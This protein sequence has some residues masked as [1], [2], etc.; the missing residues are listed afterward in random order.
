VE[1][2]GGERQ[3]SRLD[4]ILASKRREIEALRTEAW[5]AATREPIDVVRALGRAKGAP[6]RL[7]AEVKRK[8]P[9]A[10]ALSR[11]LSPAARAVAYATH[12]AAMV[13]VLCDGP[14]FDGGW[15]HV[16]EARAAIDAAGMATPLLAKEF[17]ID[18]VQIE[19]ARAAG[20]DAVLLIARIVTA[21]QLRDLAKAARAMRIEPL[22]EVVDE[23]EL[24][25]ALSAEARV[26]GVNA[27]DL[28]TL[29]MDSARAARV[30]GAVPSGVVA[31]HLSGVRAA[32]DVRAIADGRA[33]AALLGEVLMRLDDPTPLLDELVA[34]ARSSG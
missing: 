25:V 31:V 23:K 18:E 33:D 27:R 14:F 26:V 17:V 24:D 16:V 2:R 13:S 5:P 30:V 1:E 12:G 32:A 19:R 28:D 10:G 34:A 29:V 20:G 9:S 6:L 8:S 7:V 22:V 3:V 15:A 11:V 21:A 4:D